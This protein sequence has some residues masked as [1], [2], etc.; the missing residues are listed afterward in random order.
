MDLCMPRRA[1]EQ[2]TPSTQVV[3]GPEDRHPA[4]AAA[5]RAGSTGHA[6]S[7]S[8]P[9]SPEAFVALGTGPFTPRGT[10]AVRSSDA[11]MPG[12]A[13]REPSTWA[14]TQPGRSTTGA[15]HPGA[16]FERTLR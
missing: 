3:G 9:P 12:L 1:C 2:A 7:S 5:R 14:E 10:P 15:R 16:A 4:A 8:L 6:P 13:S 11:P